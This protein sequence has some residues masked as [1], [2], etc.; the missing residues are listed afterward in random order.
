M[1]NETEYEIGDELQRLAE[2]ISAEVRREYWSTMVAIL[3]NELSDD[4]P[5]DDY[6]RFLDEVRKIA[7][8]TE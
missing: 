4:V 7:G 1:L 6:L 3:V 8:G 5:P 2:R